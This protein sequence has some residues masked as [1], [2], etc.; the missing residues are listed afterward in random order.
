[1]PTERPKVV[2]LG[3]FDDLRSPDVRFLQEAARRG[4]VE[5]LLLSDRAADFSAD[6]PPAFPVEERQYLVEAIRYVS[7]VRVIDEFKDPASIVARC[8]P[9]AKA[10]AVREAEA[11]P[12][13]RSFCESAG[14]EYVVIRDEELEGFPA[15]TG[16][17]PQERPFE[18]QKKAIVTGCY[19]WLHSG[20]IRFF[21]EVSELAELY[22]TVG[23]DRN[24]EHLKGEGHPLFP[25]EERRYMVGSIRYVKQALVASGWGW[26]D[27]EPDIEVIRPD[28]YAVNEDG[29]RPEK[30]EFCESHGIE[31]RVLRRLPRPG[32]PARQS[33]DFRGF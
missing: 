18:G 24:I 6:R 32:L 19:D 12:T 8:A 23:S 25:E 27:A 9:G 26:L 10:W 16:P 21:E 13:A 17:V 7:D 4:A 5:V 28:I 31:Y 20:H 14:L 33:T 3:S 22:V 30:R 15:M 11:S 1:M 29:D 2:V